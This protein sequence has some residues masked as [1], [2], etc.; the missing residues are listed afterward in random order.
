[1]CKWD[2]NHI[3]LVH[4]GEMEKYT[5]LHYCVKWGNLNFLPCGSPCWWIACNVAQFFP[6]ETHF[7]PYVRYIGGQKFII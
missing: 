5:S 3:H 7:G 6:G 1:M 4:M 2:L